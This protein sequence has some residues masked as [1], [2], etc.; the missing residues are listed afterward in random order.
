MSQGQ[1]RAAKAT[2]LYEA[3]ILETIDLSGYDLDASLLNEKGL[4]T[5]LRDIFLKEYGWT[6]S[7]MSKQKALAE[8]LSGLPSVLTVDFYYSDILERAEKFGALS[9]KA[10][11]KDSDAFLSSYWLYVSMRVLSLFRKHDLTLKG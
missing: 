8:W 9:L 6:L 1:K 7:R 4:V 5:K 10:K 3:Y 2:K 11:E